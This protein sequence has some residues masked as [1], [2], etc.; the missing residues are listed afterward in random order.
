VIRF[1]NHRIMGTPTSE[2]GG[3]SFQN[4]GLSEFKALPEQKVVGPRVQKPEEPKQQPAD[5]ERDAAK[6]LLGKRWGKTVWENP[7]QVPRPNWPKQPRRG[8]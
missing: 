1:H 7:I 6:Q 3:G 5:Q 2:T 4:Q 8:S